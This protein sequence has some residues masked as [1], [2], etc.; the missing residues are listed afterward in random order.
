MGQHGADAGLLGNQH[1]AA[2]RILQQTEGDASPLIRYRDSEP[3]QKSV[4]DLWAT[5]AARRST[6]SCSGVARSPSR[7]ERAEGDDATAVMAEP[8]CLFCKRQNCA[9]LQAKGRIETA[10]AE[11]VADFGRFG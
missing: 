3:H 10:L 9:Y 6:T 5:S 11:K 1:R 4:S 2:N 8:L 7:A